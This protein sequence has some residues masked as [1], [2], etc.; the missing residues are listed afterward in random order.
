MKE[1]TPYLNHINY[2]RGIAIIFIVFGHCFNVGFSHY[3]QNSSQFAIFL[4]NLLPGGTTFFVFI[5]GYLFHHIY[6]KNFN[7]GDFL[8]KKLKYVFVPF[9]LISS[10]D[11]FYYLSRYIIAII[12]SSAKSEIYLSKLKSYSFF[13]TYLIGHGDIT[14]GLWYIP[15]ITIIFF[16]STVF[17]KFIKIKPSIQLTVINIL[18]IFSILVHRNGTNSILGIFQNVIYFIP[19]YFLGIYMSINFKK[20]YEKLKGKELY[21]LLIAIGLAIIQTRI[22]PAELILKNN[23]KIDKFDFMIIQK[24]FLSIFFILFLTRFENKKFKVLNILADNSFGIF[25]I[26]GICIW[27]FNTIVLK[28][29]ISFATNSFLMYLVISTLI[30]TLSLLITIL[31]RRANPKNSK[32]IIG[33]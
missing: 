33:C 2:F 23:L 25:F 28:L 26:H 9:L 17:I 1:E 19:V 6:F 29:K 27:I 32:Y 15:F 5:S 11:I 22:V 24:C 7:Y 8:I 12:S 16:L 30:L 14:I 10:I 13:N 21:I 18:L 3:Y 31:I 4:R 20:F